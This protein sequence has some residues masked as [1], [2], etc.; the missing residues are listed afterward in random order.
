ML[1]KLFHDGKGVVR[2]G[3]IQGVQITT[4]CECAELLQAWEGCRAAPAG[5]TDL[6]FY[7]N[8]C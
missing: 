1:L 3:C 5:S 7:G 4:L 8:I 6:P 2:T